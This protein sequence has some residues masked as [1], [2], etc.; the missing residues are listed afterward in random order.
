MKRVQ[1]GEI[2]QYG[3]AVVCF[4]MAV[5]CSFLVFFFFV[6]KD[7]E[8]NVQKTITN[9]VNRQ[10]RHLKSILETQYEYL[11]GVADYL[12]QAEELLSPGNME[13]IHMVCEN[14]ELERTCIVDQEGMAH[15]DTGEV[16]SVGF[17]R[18]F[19]EGISGQRTLSDPL[20]SR[21]D[22][23][24]RVVLGVPVYKD[25]QVI[26][27]LGGSYDVTA[28]SQMLFEDIYDGRGFSMILMADG[29]VIS[30]DNEGILTGFDAEG[31]FIEYCQEHIENKT[32]LEKMEQDFA[33]ESSGYLQ[34][35][36]EQEKYY[37]AY[38]PLGYNSWM[39]CYLVP[40][41]A[42]KGSYDFITQYEIYLLV[43]FILMVLVLF[44]NILRIAGKKQRALMRYA[45]TDALT[46]LANKQST[47]DGIQEWLA[48]LDGQ[49]RGLQ[50][51]LI[52][53]I[54]FFKSI[55]DQYGHAVGDEVLRRIG[56]CLKST[57]RQDDI[58]G[59]I[60]GDEFVVLMKNISTVSS[61]EKKA[62][63]LLAK[64]RK[65]E[66][67][68]MK[69]QKLTVSIGMSYAPNHGEGYLALYKHADMALYETK[70]QGRDGYTVYKNQTE[71]S[72]VMK[73]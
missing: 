3:K 54:D 25:G 68:E 26:G 40:A 56:Q 63:E 28:L 71:N 6:Q 67:T 35:T 64:V 38:V 9:N 49:C 45:A 11:D 55:N 18:Y 7:V 65:I 59:R 41:D 48:D 8:R 17:R 72:S 24:T 4:L 1:E 66:I 2:R 23:A 69:G 20:E 57:F 43:A 61:A 21:L 42:A 16:K 58:L 52:M 47:E 70:E 44:W 22:G 33:E 51:F 32:A 29:S 36:R 60:G 5:L 15:Y 31:N 73:N 12:G 50:T 62:K 34:M 14:S 53:D 10:S 13:L 27:V 39:I 19:Q 46:G 30:C 37:A